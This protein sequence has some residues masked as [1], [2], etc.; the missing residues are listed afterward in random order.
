MLQIERDDPKRWFIVKKVGNT[1]NDL[2]LFGN[3]VSG[4]VLSTGQPELLQYL[5]E[6]ELQDKVN[7]IAGE[8]DYYEQAAMAPW[9]SG[10]F[11]GVSVIYGEHLPPDPSP[12]LI[13]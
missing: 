5:T 6:E 3:A 10:K 7:E 8:S 4:S 9:E 1:E 2:V 13:K 12:P 11:N